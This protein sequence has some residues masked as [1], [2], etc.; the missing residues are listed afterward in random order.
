MHDGAASL[1]FCAKITL[2]RELVHFLTQ[3]VQPN[4]VSSPSVPNSPHANY[5]RLQSIVPSWR[6]IKPSGN[7]GPPPPRTSR[8]L[9]ESFDKGDCAFRL[10]TTERWTYGHALRDFQPKMNPKWHENAQ[11]HAF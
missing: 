8:Y 2:S 7:L 10:P 9:S 11:K 1:P 4:L 3:G 6:T 5:F